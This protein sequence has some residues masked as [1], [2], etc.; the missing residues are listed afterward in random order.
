MFITQKQEA[1][2]IFCKEHTTQSPSLATT[3]RMRI[4][5]LSASNHAAQNIRT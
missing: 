3:L 1:E 4:D 2:N 5:K